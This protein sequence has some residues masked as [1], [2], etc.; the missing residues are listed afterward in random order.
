MS[1]SPLSSS[2]MSSSP[3]S[4]SS[5]F[6]STVPPDRS[7]DRSVDDGPR[8]FGP[9]SQAALD[10]QYDN[11]SKV[12]SF[13]TWLDRYRDDSA[14]AREQW[15]GRARFDV[16]VGATPIE[17]VDV[18]PVLAGA[19]RPGV[20]GG[21]GSAG[22]G[23]PAIVFIHGGYWMA[24]EKSLFSF[25]ASG[26][27][28]HGIAAVVINYAKI[29]A[30]RMEEI[31]RQSRQAVAWAVANAASFGADPTRVGVAG[32]SA[33]GHLAAMVGADGWQPGRPLVAGYAMSGL[34]DLEPIRRSYLQKTLNLDDDDV[35]RFSPIRTRPPL[36]GHWLAIVGGDEGPEYLRQS[37][38]LAACWQSAGSRS[39]AFE[40]ARGHNHFSLV[41]T[42]ANPDDPVTR[43]VAADFLARCR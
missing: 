6:S 16:R 14:R 30:V 18:F 12:A 29:P 38:E 24:L 43:R 20:K 33:G 4:P 28:A 40:A 8:V 13:Q 34:H 17:T 3:L 2:P 7:A 32:F 21:P 11:R 36:T 19:D 9:Y 42:L 1:S 25:V 22:R 10:A 41:H 15:G 35:A 39:V 27:A 23:T 26:L 37:C 31:V 5:L